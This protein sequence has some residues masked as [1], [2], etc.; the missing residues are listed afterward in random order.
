M[1][2]TICIILVV[3]LLAFCGCNVNETKFTDPE[4]ESQENNTNEF[5]N[6][7]TDYDSGKEYTALTSQLIDMTFDECIAMSTDIVKATY[8]GD[9]ITNGFYSDLLFTVNDTYKSS[10][11]VTQI[12]VRL[13]ENTF[14]DDESDNQGD[15]GGYIAGQSYILLLERFVSV[16]FDYDVYLPLVNT[17]ITEAGNAN[18]STL[19]AHS[20][21]QSVANTDAV[22]QHIVKTIDGGCDT[23]SV[24]GDYIKSI[25]LDD[26]VN[27]SDLIVKVMVDSHV[28]HNEL[29]GTDVYTCH[30]DKIYKGTVTNFETQI[31]FFEDSV[32]EGQSYIV[33]LDD[34]DSDYYTLSSKNSVYSADQTIE[35]RIYSLVHIARSL[36]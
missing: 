30:I 24:K 36:P 14:C 7:D 29:N 15:I 33:M 11:T 20:G 32:E 5:G 18:G 2:K 22:I 10:D 28:K 16:Y 31:F 9:V 19:E 17:H 34:R 12:H 23:S 3:V 26:I 1:K 25:A 13:T 27:G 21:M 8:T 35:S 6:N 4:N